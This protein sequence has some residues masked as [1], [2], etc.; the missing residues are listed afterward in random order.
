M[1]IYI[2]CHGP[3]QKPPRWRYG[4][5]Q[6]RI[7]EPGFDKPSLVRETFLDPGCGFQPPGRARIL[8]VQKI[9]L[10]PKARTTPDGARCG[11]KAD[12]SRSVKKLTYRGLDKMRLDH[13]DFGQTPSKT[14]FLDTGYSRFQYMIDFKRLERHAGSAGVR[15]S[16]ATPDDR[17]RQ[18]RLFAG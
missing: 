13:D 1:R 3:R 7:T 12:K 2:A 17:D 9:I 15:L 18:Y 16:H 4:T 11:K 6:G 5:R 14:T 10:R 8:I